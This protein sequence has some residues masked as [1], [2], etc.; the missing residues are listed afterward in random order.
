MANLKMQVVNP[1]AATI[2]H[3]LGTAATLWSVSS[4]ATHYSFLHV[5]SDS[6]KLAAW[7]LFSCTSL[8]ASPKSSSTHSMLEY[9]QS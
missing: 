8:I 3:L 2:F 1:V 7:G 5:A 9:M 6:R 4:M